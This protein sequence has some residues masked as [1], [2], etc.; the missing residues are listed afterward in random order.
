MKIS[1]KFEYTPDDQAKARDFI[2]RQLRGEEVKWPFTASK[3]PM[4]FIDGTTMHIYPSTWLLTD[5]TCYVGGNP[6]GM[7]DGPRLAILGCLIS[8]YGLQGDREVLE[9]FVKAQTRVC[10]G[11]VTLTSATLVETQGEVGRMAISE[12]GVACEVDG[13]WRQPITGEPVDVSGEEWTILE[14]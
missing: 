5:T 14:A 2:V 9:E 3:S 8:S 6:G 10:R 11:L 13:E 4:V 7:S 12:N 1:T